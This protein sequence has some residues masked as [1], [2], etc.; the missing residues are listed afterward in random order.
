MYVHLGDDVM[1]RS[2]EIIAILD[3]QTVMD[4]EEMK[5]LLE[6]RKSELMNI[7]NGAFKSLVI[8]STHMYLSP[9]AIATLRKKALSG[10]PMNG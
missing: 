3:K 7:S 5:E 9:I 2:S 6:K 1:I 8:T 10:V 4:S